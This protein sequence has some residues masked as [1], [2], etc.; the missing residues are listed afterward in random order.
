MLAGNMPRKRELPAIHDWLVMLAHWDSHQSRPQLIL[1]AKGDT[2]VPM[3]Q[4][5]EMEEALRRNGEV[6]LVKV[7]N[8]GCSLAKP[9]SAKIWVDEEE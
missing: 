2:V 8:D 1:Y 3:N 9:R 6:R 7:D 5:T 4:A